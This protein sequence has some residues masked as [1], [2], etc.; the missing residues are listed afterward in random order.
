MPKDS[1]KVS[2]SPS[3]KQSDTSWNWRLSRSI[4]QCP[5]DVVFLCW[6]FRS[7]SQG[8][9]REAA[10]GAYIFTLG[11]DISSDT[12]LA[13]WSRHFFYNFALLIFLY[14]RG[15]NLT[16]TAF[17]KSMNL[18][19]IMWLEIPFTRGRH[20]LL[21]PQGAQICCVRCVNPNTNWRPLAFPLS[22]PLTSPHFAP[23]VPAL[24][25]GPLFTG[26]KPVSVGT[27]HLE[28]RRTR[29]WL[30]ERAKFHFKLEIMPF[31]C[32]VRIVEPTSTRDGNR[33]LYA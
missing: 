16:L 27:W 20:S 33:F 21:R 32:T 12:P 4:A 25:R 1:R 24:R 15:L 19:Y 31:S 8:H 9:R 13:G 29:S 6:C 30:G 3:N 2:I 7:E 17:L 26:L 23:H 5:V 28:Q 11:D 18:Q 22:S 10:S 14:A